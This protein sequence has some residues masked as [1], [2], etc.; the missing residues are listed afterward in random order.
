MIVPAVVFYVI[1]FGG[2]VCL[3]ILAY[4]I[5]LLESAEINRWR[6]K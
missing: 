4:L 6:H 5:W 3:A 1:A 2:L